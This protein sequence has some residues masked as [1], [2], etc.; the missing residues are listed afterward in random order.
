MDVVEGRIYLGEPG[1]KDACIGI[2]DGRIVNLAKMLDGEEHHHFGS[3]IIIPAGVDIHVHF[4]E[5]G[6]TRK[7]DFSSGSL[8]AVHGGVTTVVDM[9]ASGMSED[10]ILGDFP[11]LERQDIREALRYAA[12]GR[13]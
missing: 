11:D 9:V 3:N 8:A 1:I 2:E 13:E 5:P 7:E 10:D 12:A 6:H 4:R